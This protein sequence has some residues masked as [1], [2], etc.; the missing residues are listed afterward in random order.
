VTPIVF[1]ESFTVRKIGRIAGGG[2]FKCSTA[3]YRLTLSISVSL[4]TVSLHEKIFQC[5]SNDYRVRD[6]WINSNKE[7]GLPCLAESSYS[8]YVRC[9]NKTLKYSKSKISGVKMYTTF[10][11]KKLINRKSVSLMLCSV[12]CVAD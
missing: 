4:S 5:A 12:M 8:T 7:K 3:V 9:Y 11:T 10:E 6:E 2:D 1:C